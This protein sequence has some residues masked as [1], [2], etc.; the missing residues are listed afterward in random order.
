MES[1]T[2]QFT[3]Q[4]AATFGRGDGVAGLVDEEIEH[5]ADGLPYL[6]GRTLKGLL[7]EECANV[8]Y[9]LELQ[10]K[11]DQWRDLAY[12]MF[13]RPGSLLA[14]TGTLRVGDARLPVELRQALK[15][16]VARNEVTIDEVLA[17]LT[18]IRRQTSLNEYGGPEY[19]SLR[20][21]RVILPGTTFEAAL[22]FSSKPDTQA[23]SLLAACVLAWRR[24]GINRNR[25]RGRL[26]ASLFD[27]QRNDITAAL[28]LPF[29]REVM[30]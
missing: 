4:S 25:G 1:L 5:D 2:L 16:I 22:E 12:A 17:A 18:S 13:G 9:A 10:G 28:F 3:L 24:A 30:P 21:M 23:L 7:A 8:L 26:V 14:D 20:S 11:A 19:G 15:A 6:R 29:A 27:S